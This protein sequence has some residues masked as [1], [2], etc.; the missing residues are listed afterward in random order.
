MN[1]NDGELKKDYVYRKI[2]EMIRTEKIKDGQFP[3]EP[4]FS[5]QLRV[6]R[7]TL[8]SALKR[9]E[10]EGFI[11]RSHYYGTRVI[12]KSVAKKILIADCGTCFDASVDPKTYQ[13]QQIFLFCNK[14]SIPYDVCSLYFLEDPEKLA[15]KYSGIIFFGAA[16][17]G[18][19]TFI[20]TILKSGLPT[21][22]I[23]QDENNTI[24]DRIASVG[25]N[26]KEA[27]IAGFNYLASIGFRR[28]ATVISSDERTLQ[29]IGFTRESMACYY[30]SRG[31]EEAAGMVVNIPVD[32]LEE[33]A[34]PFVH[35]FDPEAIFCYSD[36]YALILF[37]IL[38][39]MGKRIPQDIAVMGFGIGSDLVKP[40]LSS[41]NICSP[42]CGMTAVRLLLHEQTRR[43]A[44]PF[45]NLPFNIAVHSST[46][47]I[48]IEAMI[49]N[50]GPQSSPAGKSGGDSGPH[51]KTNSSE[52][53]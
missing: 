30:R 11:T 34:E 2:L 20:Q 9:L 41:V 28:I 21:V 19:E 37:K 35:K 7:V 8:R 10:S 23:R 1:R 48:K 40:S 4:E 44:V 3:S 33:K 49:R 6:S 53:T 47:E 16:I 52:M 18:N 46:S 29:R 25:I 50:A 45:I 36:Y 15:S 22:F 32:E 12:A 24:T 14:W 31:F 17:T 51:S 5:R 38:Q 27:W 42:M 39:R 13:L 26:V 43:G